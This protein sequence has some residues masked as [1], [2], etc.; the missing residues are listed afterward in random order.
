MTFLPVVERELRV[1]A[2][3]R[4]T[5]LIRLI[6]GAIALAATWWSVAASVGAPPASVG[7]QLFR[8]LSTL[9]FIYVGILGT[10]ATAD[11]LTEEKREGT[12]G[13]LFLTDLKGYDV[14]L[15]KLTATSLHSFYGV[16]AVVPVLA[17]PLV[18]GGVSQNEVFRVVVV[19]VNLLLLSLS[20]GMFVSAISRKG[21]RA[22]GLAILIAVALLFTVSLAAQVPR[23]SFIK[24]S[25][26]AGISSPALGFFLAF[27]DFTGNNHRL[28]FWLNAL[29]TLF[30]SCVFLGLACWIV[31]RSWQDVPVGKTSRRIRRRRIWIDPEQRAHLLALNPFL[32]RA[33]RPGFKRLSVW[34]LVG[35][36]A[37]LWGLG[38][39]ATGFK[40][41]DG[42]DVDVDLSFLVWTGLM[43]K[44]W[45]ASEAGRA[46]GDD[47]R[48]GALELVLTAGL[49]P[50]QIVHGQLKSIGRQ[51][52]LPIAALLLLNVFFLMMEIYPQHVLWNGDT[53]MLVYS[54]LAVGIFLV[55][56]CY[57]LSW[58]GTW[59]GFKARKANRSAMPALFCVIGIPVGLFLMSLSLFADSSGMGEE[60]VIFLWCLSGAAIDGC[61]WA[62]ATSRLENDF[63]K[64][65]SE[66]SLNVRPA[67]GKAP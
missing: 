15:G 1:A 2:R 51:F 7:R 43:I 57:V 4:A 34:L 49:G 5:Y 55:A 39:W 50:A 33:S 64:I 35:T 17:V 37:I 60:G 47:R 11:C 52:S 20:I 63:S 56:D 24:D 9:V 36:L 65:A 27:D 66:G 12:L 26:V 29:V 13:L 67:T 46:L 21:S 58:L 3:R 14:V 23:L 30:Y 59:F 10:Q 45:V 42:F 62:L 38:R 32:W 48:S 22:H 16:L 19:S 54:H 41:G 8:F 18:M 53:R 44:A 28:D 40:R 6:A 61:F 31:P 25:R